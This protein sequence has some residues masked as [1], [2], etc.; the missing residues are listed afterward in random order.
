MSE[1]EP[2]QT[3]PCPSE[4]QSQSSLND[5]SE[6][7]QQS[8]VREEVH[9]TESSFVTSKTHDPPNKSENE[10]TDKP[11]A[12]VG[13]LPLEWTKM[14][15]A[16]GTT[17]HIYYPSDV[18]D[19]IPEDTSQSLYIVGTHG[20]KITH[21]GK[22]LWKTCAYKTMDTLVLR[23]HLIS[24]MEGLDGFQSLKT[25]ELYDNQISILENLNNTQ[26]EQSLEES[27]DTTSGLTGRTLNV[28]DMSF[29]VIRDMAP[30]QF[31]P[32][33]VELCK[34]CRFFTDNKQFLISSQHFL[35]KNQTWQTTRSKKS[36]VFNH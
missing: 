13:E 4:Q 28:L 16:K 8:Q 6:P 15:T 29:N 7:S 35:C 14:G 33:L 12:K 24:V 34:S 25:L 11:R 36:R 32:N 9:Y 31:C 26:Q 23:S 18:Q 1:D 30:V 22:D 20:R 2:L 5:T 19:Y 3:G 27:S 10:V 17:Q 21:M